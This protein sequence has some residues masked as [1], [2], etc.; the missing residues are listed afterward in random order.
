METI[1][2]YFVPDEGAIPAGGMMGRLSSIQEKGLTGVAVVYQP[3]REKILQHFYR[4]NIL[5]VK[6]GQDSPAQP[7][8]EGEPVVLKFIQLTPHGLIHSNL[9]TSIERHQRERGGQPRTFSG[10]VEYTSAGTDPYILRFQW[11]KAGGSILFNA[12]TNQ[13]HSL[14]VSGRT[15]ID[16]SGAAKTILDKK[17]EPSC[18]VVTYSPN[19]ALEPWQEILIRNSFKVLADNLLERLETLT[20]R[21]ITYSFSRIL[22]AYANSK[23]L[24]ISISQRQW[25]NNHVFDTVESAAAVYREVFIELMEHFSA[26]IGPRL[27]ESNLQDVFGNLSESSLRDLSQYGVLPQGI[28][29]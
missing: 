12:L 2:D 19:A 8:P 26:V 24:D 28:V 15:M 27:L 20:G 6:D 5:S 17:D 21:V 16:Q 4:G 25:I 10:Q 14:Y 11:D 1:Y 3:S 22:S 9:L 18:K 29:K 23:N 13:P 7:V